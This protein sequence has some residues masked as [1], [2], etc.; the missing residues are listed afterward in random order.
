M[1]L[2]LQT[3][4]KIDGTSESAG[5]SCD[6]TQ[7]NGAIQSGKIGLDDADS[8]RIGDDVETNVALGF[9]DLEVSEW[10]D[11]SLTAVPGKHEQ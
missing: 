11:E 7:T 3:K 10:I 9:V 5:V 8:K 4:L 1:H 6:G 2:A